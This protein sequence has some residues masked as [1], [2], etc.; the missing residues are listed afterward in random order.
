M[1]PAVSVDTITQFHTSPRSAHE[2]VDADSCMGSL[3]ESAT[4]ATR[5]TLSLLPQPAGAHAATNTSPPFLTTARAWT[6]RPTAW[7]QAKPVIES[8]RSS[9]THA[10]VSASTAWRLWTAEF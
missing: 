9:S 10:K 8:C 7:H 5:S 6:A 2:A 3:N 4:R 1:G